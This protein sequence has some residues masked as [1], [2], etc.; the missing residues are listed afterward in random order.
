MKSRSMC[1]LLLAAAVA[2]GMVLFL[3]RFFIDGGDWA[4]SRV[5]GI[6]YSGGRLRCGTILDR[7]GVELTGVVDGERVWAEDPVVRRATL[8]VVGDRNGY[9]G[10]GALRQYAEELLGYS[11]VTGLAGMY[12]EDNVLE[13]SIDSS[14][15]A[16]A[17]EALNGRSGAVAVM[18]CSTG[19]LLCEVSSPTF[20]PASPPEAG[21]DDGSGVYLNRFLSSSY[22]PGSIFKLVTLTAALE[23][24]DGLSDRE[25][26]CSGS[27][28][29]G[30]GSVTCPRAHGEL[31]IEDALAVSCNCTFA[32]LAV[33]IGAETIAETASELGL[34]SELSVDGIATASGRYDAADDAFDVAWSGVGQSTDL[35]NPAS[36]LRFMS[37]IANSGMA[38]DMTQL[39]GGGGTSR[40]IMSQETADRISE[41]M[42]YCVYLT[43]GDENFPGLDLHAKSGTAE[44]GGDRQPN[45]WFVGFVRCEDRSLAFVVVIEEGGSGSGAAGPVANKVLQAAVAGMQQD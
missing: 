32:G 5:N 14:L 21:E 20:D 34:T 13:L 35:I 3:F 18:D 7:N 16:V 23:T 15:C 31:K 42:D 40:R 29:I 2:A 36:M 37:A 33:E 8:H 45:A 17:L 1:L 11:P 26:T 4:S 24:L 43:Y 41:M 44:V 39:K 22:T 28:S 19:E 6:A 38:A 30:D 12:D 10:T 9:I 27:V 25:F